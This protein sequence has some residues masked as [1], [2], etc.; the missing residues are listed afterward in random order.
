MSIICRV[1]FVFRSALQLIDD[2]LT[3]ATDAGKTT[4]KDADDKFKKAINA[5]IAYEKSFHSKEIVAEKMEKA[6]AYDKS[7]S[8]ILNR[9]KENFRVRE[10][11][12]PFFRRPLIP[13]FSRWWRNRR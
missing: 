1:Q 2:A 8:T 13:I 6:E 7:S 12:A 4:S 9:L 5:L 11:L 10:Y 3:A